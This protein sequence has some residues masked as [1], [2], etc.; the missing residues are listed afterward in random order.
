MS[1]GQVAITKAM[2][3]FII[4]AK[5][6]DSRY[7]RFVNV[8]SVAGILAPPTMACYTSSKFAFGMYFYSLLF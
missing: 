5:K 3:E 1:V 7:G 4:D 6:N 8:T 2:K